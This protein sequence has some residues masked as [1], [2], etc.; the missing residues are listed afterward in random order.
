M[1]RDDKAF[2]YPS[3]YFIEYC[4]IMKISEKEQI[5]VFGEEWLNDFKNFTPNLENEDFELLA[6]FTGVP[7]EFW[8]N[9]YL[10]YVKYVRLEHLKTALFYL[11]TKDVF[12]CE[13]HEQFRK[14]QD[15][16]Y[17]IRDELYNYD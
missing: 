4:E 10:K 16:I 17:A 11:D 5:K 2:S 15:E 13:D 9:A 3:R 6:N 14:Y 8:E 1:H 12:D 7:I